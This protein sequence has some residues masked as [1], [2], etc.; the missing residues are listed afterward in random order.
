[1]ISRRLP[2]LV[3]A[4]VT[5]SLGAAALSCA[6]AQQSAAPAPTAD[7]FAVVRATSQAAYQ[8]GKDLVD[9]GDILRGCPLIDTAKTTDPDNRP[10]I[11]Q[12][13]EQCI[14]A[15][16]A[17]LTAEPTATTAAVVQR[18]LVV[19]TVPVPTPA[20]TAAVAVPPGT[21]AVA[22]ST[23]IA[24]SPA[25]GAS[26]VAADLQSWSDPQGRFAI[27]YQRDWSKIDQPQALFG[28][29]IVEFR[30]PSNRANVGVAVDSSV[31]AVSPELYAASMEL[32]MQQQVPGY[33]LEQLVPGS[34]AGNPSIRRVFTYTQRDASGREVNARSFQVTVLKGSTPYIVSGAA[35]AD[36]FAS[37]SRVFD[38]MVESFRF[39]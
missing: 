19:A 30:D 6:P 23:V 1:L 24:V 12:A 39:L 31:K 4:A 16:S 18:T 21:A 2:L 15:L 17:Q 3:V 28:N 9:R 13:L 36:Q 5:L 10:D 26:V 37:F 34:T 38:Q 32:L 22:A 25:A 7:P 33:A 14:A 35:P 27:G 11:Q 8:T 29:G 20:A